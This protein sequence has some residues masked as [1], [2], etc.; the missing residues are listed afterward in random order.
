MLALV[1]VRSGNKQTLA[2][3]IT[4]DLINQ[5]IDSRFHGAA[6]ASFV[7]EALRSATSELHRRTERALDLRRASSSLREYCALIDRLLGFYEPLEARLFGYRNHALSRKIDLETRRKVP[8]L[9]ADLATLNPALFRASE[10]C[11]Y[12]PALDSE[13]SAIG[14][15]YVVEGAT[16]GGRI[17]GDHLSRRLGISADSGARFFNCYGDLRERNW[18]EFCGVLASLQRTEARE[19]V[20]G[21]VAVFDAM[22]RWLDERPEAA[23]RGCGI[24]QLS[25]Q[26]RIPNG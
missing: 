4:A 22:F 10:V 8:A 13:A 24:V 26:L 17:I 23:T 1:S 14:A 5:E 2:K 15:W 3:P 16:L 7:L 18:N 20:A 6:A 25:D 19:V 11:P 12:I 9:Y 21:A